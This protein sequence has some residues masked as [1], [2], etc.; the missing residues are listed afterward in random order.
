MRQAVYFKILL[1]H[2]IVKEL[3]IFHCTTKI[4]KVPIPSSTHI[5]TEM[6]NI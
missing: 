1:I 6:G 5:K 3:L 4:L 2:C